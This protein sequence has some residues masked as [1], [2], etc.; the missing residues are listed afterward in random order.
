MCSFNNFLFVT[1]TNRSS[2]HTESTQLT[3]AHKRKMLWAQANKAK[4]CPQSDLWNQFKYWDGSLYKQGPN[5]LFFFV[6]KLQWPPT[7]HMTTPHYPFTNLTLDGREWH[8][9]PSTHHAQRKFRESLTYRSLTKTRHWS[10]NKWRECAWGSPK[11]GCSVARRRRA[12]LSP[13]LL[14]C[15]LRE[16]GV[17]KHPDLESLWH[18]LAACPAGRSTQPWSVGFP[19]LAGDQGEEDQTDAFACIHSPTHSDDYASLIP[20]LSSHFSRT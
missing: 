3:S 13:E 6:Y 10:K 18:I 17:G 8:R 7:G 14:I 20:T 12:Q 1:S 11:W 4:L 19:L 16:S 15:F 5:K 2:H 9:T